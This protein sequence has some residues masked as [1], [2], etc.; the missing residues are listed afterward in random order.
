MASTIRWGILGPG[1]IAHAFAEGLTAVPDA[2]LLACASRTQE[3][4]AA[5]GEKW[6]VP[7]C[8]G[9]YEELVADPDVDAIY[10]AT[11]HPMHYEHT[12]LCLQYGKAVLCEKPF[13]V[14]A[15]ETEAIIAAARSAQRLV[16]EAMWS[17]F[18]PHVR[19]AEQLVQEGAIGD[20]RLL[21]ADFAFR[22]GWDLH[23]RLLDPALAGG[24]L[25]DVGVYT[26]SLAQLFF[27]TPVAVA[28]QAHLGE[29]GVDEQAVMALAY[30]EGRL[31]SL[32]CGVRTNS[33]HEALIMGTDGCIRLHSPWWRPSALTLSV[34]GQDDKR[35]E[36]AITGNGY[37]YQAIEFG[38]C[39]REG[40]TESPLRPLDETLAVMRTLDTLRAQWGLVYPMELREVTVEKEGR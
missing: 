16:M 33:P 8:Y 29:T 6:Q 3:H 20:V 17:R 21:Q 28:G 1:N 36:P 12:L 38:R 34:Y 14:N 31:A 7:R 18:L 39:L 9:S 13:T 37:N 24:G 2:E 23:S 35:I 22:C 25:L 40:L 11:P 32:C 4:A 30:P 26:V 5:F 10:I 19:Q 15:R 27:G